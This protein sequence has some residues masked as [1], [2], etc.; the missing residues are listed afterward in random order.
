MKKC[1][2][3]LLGCLSICLAAFLTSCDNDSGSKI[4][5]ID[6]VE[7]STLILDN[8][9]YS[10]EV[11]TENVNA[12]KTSLDGDI[13]ELQNYLSDDLISNLGFTA[14]S[15]VRAMTTTE[16]QQKISEELAAKI[17][18]YWN[19]VEE[20]GS[21]SFSYTITPGEITDAPEGTT[22]TIPYFSVS[23]SVK[24][25]GSA[26]KSSTKTAASSNIMSIMTGDILVM[27]PNY[28]GNLRKYA[29][30]SNQNFNY[31]IT[32][33]V[34]WNSFNLEDYMNS[35][36]TSFSYTDLMKL[37]GSINFNYFTSAA[38]TYVTSDSN[39]IGCKVL[40]TTTIDSSIPSDALQNFMDID[41]DEQ[42]PNS[43]GLISPVD[44]MAENYTKAKF[45]IDIY[46]SE[47]NFI[48]NYKTLE[49][50][51]EIEDYISVFDF[52]DFSADSLNNDYN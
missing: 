1:S 17:E 7:L 46:D 25:S 26:T 44:I 41:E 3:I 52:T 24:S 42:E 36:E 11:T 29:I 20:K 22:L 9:D 49:N 35:S 4:P 48:A 51:A 19:D 43:D 47:N 10:T 16:L 45:T 8:S 15:N 39:K 34:D 32:M 5:G 12:V 38:F 27:N 6:E 28:D 18:K 33:T 40:V 14:N 23:E 13:N 50:V 2:K 37:S 31:A 21:A 30:N